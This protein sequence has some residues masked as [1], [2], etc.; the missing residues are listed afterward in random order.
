[1][2]FLQ[3][4]ILVPTIMQYYINT[5]KFLKNYIFTKNRV[6][7]PSCFAAHQQKDEDKNVPEKS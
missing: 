5:S 7:Y 3:N 2:F 6:S 1:M 4:E